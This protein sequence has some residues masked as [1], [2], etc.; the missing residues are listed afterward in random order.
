MSAFLN[1]G[2]VLSGPPAASADRSSMT[3]TRRLRRGPA[4]IPGPDLDPRRTSPTGRRRFG[5]TEV[6]PDHQE[7]TRPALQRQPKAR[8]PGPK[9]RLRKSEFA[10]PQPR[11]VRRTAGVQ[12]SSGWTS[13]A[14]ANTDPLSVADS[15]GLQRRLQIIWAGADVC[16]L[17]A[18]NLGSF[19]NNLRPRPPL[20]A[21]NLGRKS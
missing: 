8:F 14:G 12:G 9:N 7:T 13:A 2:L 17:F 16:G 4:A 21:T 15:T 20:F 1:K 6:F 19:A 5:K 3:Q 10:F 18:N 11:W